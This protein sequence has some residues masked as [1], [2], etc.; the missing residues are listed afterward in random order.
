MAVDSESRGITSANNSLAPILSIVKDEVSDRI[1]QKSLHAFVQALSLPYFN[2]L[3]HNGIYGCVAD[4]GFY[5]R[6]RIHNLL[7]ADYLTKCSILAV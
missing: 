6:N 3:N 1:L 5:S 4:I 7:A 2:G